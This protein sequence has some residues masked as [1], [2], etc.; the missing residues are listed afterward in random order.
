MLV[1]DTVTRSARAV[2]RERA[3]RASHGWTGGV[4]YKVLDEGSVR[5]AKHEPSLTEEDERFCNMETSVETL[6]LKS[7]ACQQEACL[8]LLCA[9]YNHVELRGL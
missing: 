7:A 9:P 6:R 5:W 3:A 2:A 1:F 4:D 8:R